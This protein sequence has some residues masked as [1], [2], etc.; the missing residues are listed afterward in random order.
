[1]EMPPPVLLVAILAYPE[2]NELDLFGGYA[3]LAKAAELGTSALGNHILDVRIVAPHRELST[4]GG[5]RLAVAEDLD[6]LGSAHAVFIP[7]GR[8]AIAAAENE[9]LVQALHAATARGTRIYSVCSGAFLVAAA[10]LA[11]GR[12]L[13]IHAEKQDALLAGGAS[14]V[15]SGLLR[16]GPIVSIGGD[17]R[18]SVKSVDL[19]FQLLEDFFAGSTAVVANRMEV[20]QGRFVV[21]DMVGQERRP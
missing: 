5:V 7:G 9:H 17:L 18:E 15:A 3:V 12:T 4:S 16:D 21:A 19:A 10:G 8:G 20:R 2:V 6:F 14:G 11:D 13:A 1:M